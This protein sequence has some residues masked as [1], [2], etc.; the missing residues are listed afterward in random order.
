[1]TSPARDSVKCAPRREKD[2]GALRDKSRNEGLIPASYGGFLAFPAYSEG[3]FVAR[4]GVGW[5]HAQFTLQTQ[6]R[7]FFR[8]AGQ[9][10]NESGQF[11][12]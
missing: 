5:L 2:P 3:F 7:L 6:L 11:G 10:L 1:M 4:S 8:Q 12:V 9:F